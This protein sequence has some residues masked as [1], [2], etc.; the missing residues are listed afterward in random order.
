[1]SIIYLCI[2]FSLL[3]SY[4]TDPS[5]ENWKGY[6]YIA[7]LF[8]STVVSSTLSQ[9]NFHLSNTLGMRIKAAVISVIYKK[10]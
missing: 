8:V 1:M 7:L 4:T 9:Q 2:V 5:V 3:I 6:L 10:V